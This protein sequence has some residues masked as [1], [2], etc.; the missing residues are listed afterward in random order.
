MNK[1]VSIQEAVSKIKDN[2]VLLVG[3]FLGVGSPHRCIDELIKQKTKGLTLVCNDSGFPE[4]AV[5][6]LVMTKQFSKIIASHIGTNKETGRQ[7]MEGETIVELVP[8][9]TL[10]EQIRAAGY[11][12]GGVLTKTGL[13]TKVEENKQTVDI[14]GE[15]YL[16]EKPIR[17][18]VALI[19]ANK[20]DKFGNMVFHGAARNF[21][22]VMASAAD[23][24]IVEA[25]EVVEVGELD[26]DFIHCPGIFVDYI[27][28][29]GAKHG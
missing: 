10:V 25:D 7:M 9:G 28:D 20:V 14:D 8:Q 29:G 1:I 18:N 19:Y 11:G 15:T 16:L 3:G 27:V 24:V 22:P 6:K 21:N 17:G 5:G 2:D 12:L 4:I 26:P 23:I 13:G